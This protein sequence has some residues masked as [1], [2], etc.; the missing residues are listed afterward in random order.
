[1][2]I[3]L[4]ER[5]TFRGPW[6]VRVDECADGRTAELPPLSESSELAVS[7]TFEDGDDDADLE[8]RVGRVPVAALRRLRGVVDRLTAALRDIARRPALR[9]QGRLVREPALAGQSVGELTLQEACLDP[10]LAVRVG[11]GVAFREQIREHAVH[12]FDLPENRVLTG[13]LKFLQ[14]QIADLRARAGREMEQRRANRAYRDRPGDG[15][16]WWEQEDLPRIR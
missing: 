15:P 14:L 6:R 5:E 8:V 11:R 9:L 2:R 1:M 4:S 10:T 3:R 16:S 7:V 12:H 13:F